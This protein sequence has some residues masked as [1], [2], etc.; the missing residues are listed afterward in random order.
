M[1]GNFAAAVQSH[2]ELNV[3]DNKN[4][5]Y[6]VEGDERNA[7]QAMA[8]DNDTDEV[9][10]LIDT[11]KV[12]VVEVDD[13]IPLQ[14]LDMDNVALVEEHIVEVF[15]K[16]GEEDTDGVDSDT[17]VEEGKNMDN[18]GADLVE[19]N[20]FDHCVYQYRFLLAF[21]FCFL[22]AKFIKYLIISVCLSCL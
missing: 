7:L 17:L 14:G 13:E 21:C 19:H 10:Q 12:E 5:S 18:K 2:K 22:A 15:H 9:S 3:E 8:V 1:N 11:E 16:F 6:D 20:H 4:H